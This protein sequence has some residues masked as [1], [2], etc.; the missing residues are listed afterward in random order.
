[1]VPVAPKLSKVSIEVCLW[2]ALGFGLWAALGFGRQ[3][4]WD[5]AR[6]SQTDRTNGVCGWQSKLPNG[7][8]FCGSG[9]S[10]LEVGSCLG[11][12]IQATR[13]IIVRAARYANISIKGN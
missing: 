5:G 11:L 7:I 8:V 6:G 10:K 13:G 1:M 9:F 12:R 2:V 4:Q 3:C